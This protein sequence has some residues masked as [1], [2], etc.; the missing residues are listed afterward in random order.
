MNVTQQ[1]ENYVY[2]LLRDATR[3]L[4]NLVLYYVTIV[5]YKTM[6]RILKV[7]VFRP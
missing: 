6:L 5:K 3:D 2:I 7:R 4:I 1:N